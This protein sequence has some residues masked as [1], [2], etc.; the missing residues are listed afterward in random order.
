MWIANLYGNIFR[1]QRE[2]KAI[3]AAAL[4]SVPLE[5]QASIGR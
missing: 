2:L 4:I 3:G 1:A 5:G